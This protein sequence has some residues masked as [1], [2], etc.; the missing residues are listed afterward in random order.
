MGHVETAQSM[1]LCSVLV[2]RSMD[3][4]ALIDGVQ[5]PRIVTDVCRYTTHS[6][7]P[8]TVSAQL[9]QIALRSLS[10]KCHIWGKGKGGE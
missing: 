5:L 7:T 1:D 9:L 8:R 6:V 2:Q 3:R 4:A 10:C